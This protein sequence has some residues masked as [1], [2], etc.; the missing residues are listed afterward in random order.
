MMT[1]ITVLSFLLFFFFPLSQIMLSSERSVISCEGHIHT[2]KYRQ[3]VFSL[4][5]QDM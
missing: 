3:L 4:L 5:W 2:E 1:V